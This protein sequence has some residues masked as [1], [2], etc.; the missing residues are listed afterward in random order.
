MAAC[1]L[2]F[3]DSSAVICCAVW[4]VQAWSKSRNEWVTTFT[5]VRGGD[6][7]KINEVCLNHLFTNKDFRGILGIANPD[8]ACDQGGQNVGT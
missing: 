5:N 1:I 6:Q 7:P 4:C 2:C 3:H 8:A